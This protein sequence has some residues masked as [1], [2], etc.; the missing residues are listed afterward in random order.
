[1]YI[2]FILFGQ[3]LSTIFYN[4]QN[5]RIDSLSPISYNHSIDLRKLSSFLLIHVV[6]LY[7]LLSNSLLVNF[8]YIVVYAKESQMSRKKIILFYDSSLNYRQFHKT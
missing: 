4:F 2:S 3:S 5:I 6:K 1:M 7:K 8:E